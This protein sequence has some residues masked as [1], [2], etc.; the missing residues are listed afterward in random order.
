MYEL[1]LFARI[2]GNN[3]NLQG[4]PLF[5]GIMGIYKRP[6]TSFISQDHEESENMGNTNIC[7]DHEDSE[8]LYYGQPSLNKHII[9][10][11]DFNNE[12]NRAI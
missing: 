3:L 11:S 8:I 9:R 5:A 1:P 7:L 6:W 12:S 4:L 2:L 10:G